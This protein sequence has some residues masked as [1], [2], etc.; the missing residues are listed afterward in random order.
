SIRPY[1]TLFRS[2]R[3]SGGV[4]TRV[5]HKDLN[6]PCDPVRVRAGR[7]CSM[8]SRFRILA[9]CT[10]NLCRSP[11]IEILLSDGLDKRYFEVASAGVRARRDNPMDGMAAMEVERLGHDPTGFASQQVNETLIGSAD[12]IVTATRDHRS[13]ILHTEPAALHKT[14]TLLEFAGLAPQ[15]QATDLP[16]L[17]EAAARNRGSGPRDVDIQDP[18]RLEPAI[19]RSV[20][21]QIA[22]ATSEIAR[23]LNTVVHDNP[24][25]EL[26]THR[27]R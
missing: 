23:V 18:F 19:H 11:M 27:S 3:W 6:Y 4:T 12:L 1:T 24:E 9:V 26:R 21:K 2:R 13:T 15:S 8:T 20:A 10:A 25:T 22:A 14:F 17:V 16:T 7:C 5:S